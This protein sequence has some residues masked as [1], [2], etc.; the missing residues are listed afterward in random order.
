MLQNCF[1]PQLEQLNLKDVLTVFQQDKAPCHFALR[2][3]QFLN[4]EFS[5]RWIGRGKP[6][7]WPPR[8]SDLT[9]LDC[10]WG[11]VKTIVYAT[12]PSS[13][14]YL[15]AKITNVILDIT[16]NQLA[17]VFHELQNR[18]TLCIANDGNL[19]KILIKH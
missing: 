6:F 4:Q 9:P 5:N 19:N 3:R 18:I 17:N 11:H 1:I 16:V 15:N 10:L 8:L 7:H 2:V 13:L 14:E 12:K